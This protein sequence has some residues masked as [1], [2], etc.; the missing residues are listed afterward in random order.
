MLLHANVLYA[1]FLVL[2]SKGNESKCIYLHDVACIQ[3]KQFK[4][5]L[6]YLLHMTSIALIFD[7]IMF[8]L[9]SNPMR[10]TLGFLLI[11]V[12]RSYTLYVHRAPR[13]LFMRG[14]IRVLC[15]LRANF[16][17]SSLVSQT[18]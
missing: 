18:L 11:S 13:R 17:R 3:I 9:R 12:P 15:D 14:Y 8:E 6:L 2:Q 4:Y 5:V 7:N 1:W 16:L 10:P